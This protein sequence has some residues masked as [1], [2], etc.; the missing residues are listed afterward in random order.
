MILLSLVTIKIT[1]IISKSVSISVWNL[2]FQLMLVGHIVSKRGITIDPDKIAHIVS[3]PIPTNITEVKR[4][5]GHTGYYRRFIFRYAI[6]AMPLTKF[7]K[8]VMKF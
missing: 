4:F 7:L 2:A 6:I 8:K 1:Q 3:L 5:L